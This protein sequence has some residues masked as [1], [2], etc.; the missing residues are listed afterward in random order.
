M[1][2]H[3]FPVLDVIIERAIN[4]S[5]LT[6]GQGDSGDPVI[7]IDLTDPRREGKDEV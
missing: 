2:N 7:V 6:Q 3:I 5:D 1:A 4:V